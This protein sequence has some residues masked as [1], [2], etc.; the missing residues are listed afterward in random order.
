MIACK[1]TCSR[2]CDRSRTSKETLH[3]LQICEGLLK[4]QTDSTKSWPQLFAARKH[5]FL[6]SGAVLGDLPATRRWIRTGSVN[7]MIPYWHHL[8]S[9]MNRSFIFLMECSRWFLNC[10]TIWNE[11]FN[12]AINMS[13]CEK[14]LAVQT[15]RNKQRYHSWWSCATIAIA[16]DLPNTIMS[17]PT[18]VGQKHR[19]PLSATEPGGLP[20]KTSHSVAMETKLCFAF[21]TSLSSSQTQVPH[22]SVAPC[23]LNKLCHS[24]QG[25]IKN[26]EPEYSNSY[27]RS[28]FCSILCL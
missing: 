3:I 12:L 4:R 8:A 10:G 14:N 17:P 9:V 7:M 5:Q 26:C 27:L 11:T 19:L 20:A 13:S 15:W 24:S 18:S 6:S 21:H 1:R 22:T 23:Q 25:W 16:I 2:V 28:S